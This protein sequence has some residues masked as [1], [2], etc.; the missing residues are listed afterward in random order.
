MILS[1]RQIKEKQRVEKVRKIILEVE[2]MAQTAHCC[3]ICVGDDS[4]E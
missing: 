3:Q 2:Y 4:N 1:K